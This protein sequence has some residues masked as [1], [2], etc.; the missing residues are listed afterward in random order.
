MYMP[1]VKEGIQLIQF[2]LYA[3]S[4]KEAQSSKNVNI[5]LTA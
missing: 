4:H 1:Q 3:N 5:H 2:P